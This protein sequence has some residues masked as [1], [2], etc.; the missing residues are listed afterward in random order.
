MIR[1][2]LYKRLANP[3]QARL[4]CERDGN[5]IWF[6]KHT[7]LIRLLAENCL[8]S[9]SGF[10]SGTKVDLDNSTGDKIVLLSEFHHMNDGGSYDGWSNMT[11]TIK[12]SLIHDVDIKINCHGSL[13]TKYR[14][15]LD[16]WYDTFQTELTR[17]VELDYDRE[18]EEYSVKIVA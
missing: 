8:P 5:T 18:T 13:A 14:D 15:T 10:D 6:E 11:I 12:P 4:A 1:D 7:E 9:G 16:Y 17:E 3:I 2:K